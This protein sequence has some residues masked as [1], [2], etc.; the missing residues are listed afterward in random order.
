MTGVTQLP[1]PADIQGVQSTGTLAQVKQFCAFGRRQAGVGEVYRLWR[2]QTG[3]KRAALCLERGICHFRA[4]RRP[5]S[6]AVDAPLAQ[7]GVIPSKLIEHWA[8]AES[9]PR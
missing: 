8:F 9:L 1:A 3:S 7:R 5:G 4:L 6:A 2:C